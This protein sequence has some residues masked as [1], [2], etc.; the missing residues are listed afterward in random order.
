MKAFFALFLLAPL[1]VLADGEPVTYHRDIAPIIY[2]HCTSCH[3]EGESAP[4]PLTNYSEV[5][6]KARTIRRVTG[7]RYMPPWHANSEVTE[8][9]NVR[10][11]TAEQISRIDRWVSAG[12]PE[13]DPADA[14][15]APVFTE[16]WQLGEPDLIVTMAEPYEV[17][18]DGPDIYRNFVLPLDLAEDKWV[19]AVELR[20]SAR[21]VVHHSLFHLDDS[22]TA[23]QLDGKDGKPGFSGMSFRRSGSIGTYV[24]GASPRKLPGDLARPLPRGSDLV[25]STHFHPSGKPELERTTVGIYLTDTPPARKL[26]ELQVPPAFGR[27]A[28]IDIP[29]GEANFTIRDSFTLPV[30]VEA[31]SVSG[32][33][34]YLCTTMKMTATPPEGQGPPR[35]LLE[36]PDWDLDWQDTYFF[37][38]PLVLTAGTVIESVITYDNSRD[39][40]ENPHNPPKRVKWGRESTDEMGS[41]TLAGVVLHSDEQREL[42]LSLQKQRTELFAALGRTLKDKKVLARLPAIVKRLDRN[43]NGILEES[44][45]PRRL[46]EALLLRLDQD[47]DKSLDGSEIERLEKWLAR[48]ETGDES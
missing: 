2:A 32:H 11:L 23:R 47:G 29:A 12:K 7:D 4:F 21:G 48:I 31:Y 9:L 37:A 40:P 3:R 16:G 19:K 36:I 35:I 22:G 34:H 13:G 30:D 38:E 20:P 33:A 27:K 15:D 46:R 28:G 10:R 41:I 18:A 17:P 39:N 24:P 8:F 42:R 44:E 6:R 5:S 45:L 43:D 14:P 26:E 1:P 25:L